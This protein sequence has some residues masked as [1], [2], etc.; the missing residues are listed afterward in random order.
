MPDNSLCP[1]NTACG[2]WVCLGCQPGGGFCLNGCF[3]THLQGPQECD[4]N[5]CTL[6]F[7][8]RENCITSFKCNDGNVCTTDTCDPS[9]GICGHINN[10]NPCDDGLPCTSGDVCSGGVCRGQS[11]NCDDGNACTADTCSGT[12]CVHTNISCNDG[13]VCTADLCDPATG[14]IHPPGQTTCGLGACRRTV[15]SCIDGV[16]QTCVPG[17]P[18]AEVCNGIDDDCDGLVDENGVQADCTVNPSTIN[19]GSQGSSFSMTCKL[20]NVCDPANPTPIPGSTVSQVYISRIDSADDPGDDVTLPDPA[21]LPCPDPVLGS[22][23]ERGI[24]ENLAARDVS[25]ANVTFKFNLPADGDCSTLDG[26][27]E[28]IAARLA[29]ILDNTSATICITGKA[30][31]M[32]FQACQLVLVK[33]KGLR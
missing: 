33:N 31:S 5:L 14:C 10:T 16:P 11:P 29:A 25:N 8:Q 24:S 30:G 9:V 26:N 32:G 20:T 28:D 17:T 1:P 7:C 19:L 2:T 12:S 23:Y 22:A 6:D 13:N 4:N 15:D 3:N 27:R 18:A 21:T